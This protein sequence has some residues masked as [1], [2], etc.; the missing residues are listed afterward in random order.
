[1]NCRQHRINHIEHINLWNALAVRS[2][3]RTAS[4]CIHAVN[5]KSSTHNRCDEKYNNVL[6]VLDILNVLNELS[7]LN[8][9]NAFDLFELLC[10]LKAYIL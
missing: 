8:V 9:L 7:V 6:S 4:G 5:K 1:M 10:I 3:K 2:G